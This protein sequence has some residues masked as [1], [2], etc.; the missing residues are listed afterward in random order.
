MASPSTPPCTRP[1]A[2]RS[3]PTS[4]RTPWSTSCNRATGCTTGCSGR[5]WYASPTR[6]PGSLPDIVATQKRDYYEV[7]GVARGCTA[8]EMKKA[9]RKLAMQ[10][11]PYLNHGDASAEERFKDAGEAHPLLGDPQK[12]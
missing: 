2:A 7:L 10:Y 6:W 11:H 12:R 9:Y 8:E 1:S 5:P 3:R 4:R